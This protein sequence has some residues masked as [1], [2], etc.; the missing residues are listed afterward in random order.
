MI[1]MIVQESNVER[2]N[3]VQILTSS[4]MKASGLSFGPNFLSFLFLLFLLLFSISNSIF[5]FFAVASNGKGRKVQEPISALGPASERGR[6]HQ[7]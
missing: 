5:H 1:S 7:R 2:R 3:S 6:K 4:V